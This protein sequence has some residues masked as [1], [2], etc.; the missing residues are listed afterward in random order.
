MLLRFLRSSAAPDVAQGL[1][2]TLPGLNWEGLVK[3]LES[4]AKI[5][6]LVLT[7]NSDL[8]PFQQYREARVG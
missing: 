6:V 3:F 2:D 1:E 5:R 4:T 8:A 7:L